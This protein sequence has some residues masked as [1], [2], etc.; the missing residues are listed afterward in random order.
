[1]KNWIL[2]HKK[3]VVTA[4]A[5]VVLIMALGIF[6]QKKNSIEAMR[7]ANTIVSDY[8]NSEME[9]WGEVMYSRVESISIDFPSEVTE[10]Q[11][12]E[13]ERVTLGQTLVTIDLSEYNGNIEKLRQ[14]LNA[15]EAALASA[16]QD[17]SALQTDIANTQKDIARKSEEYNNGTNA[18]IKLLNNSLNLAKKQ[19]EDA[20]NDLQNYQSLYDEGAV[21]KNTLDQYVDIVNQRQKAVD[22]LDTSIQKTKIAL[23]DELSL[24]NVSLKSKQAQLSQ[25]QQGN[26]TNVAVQ[27]SSVSV[28]EVDLNALMNKSL[29]DYIKDNQIVSNLNNGIVKNISIV[30]GSRLGTQG[31]PTQ[32]LQ[33]ID[34]DS[35]TVSAEVY[36]EF[37]GSVQVGDTVRIVP[38]SSPDLS[39]DGTVTHIPELAVEK[40]GRRVVRVIVKPDD[41]NNILKPGF[42][43]EVY[44]TK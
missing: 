16:T 1:M 30:N 41:P 25:L 8:Q 18:D 27:Q 5:F 13:G 22:D 29:R 36:E 20:K 28:T 3:V 35:I 24:L 39:L 14:Q 9:A 21:S 15:N 19:L 38:S 17:I 6:I 34:A 42:T 37:I 12:K 40:D 32:V 2:S 26:T 7:E 43:A 23:K 10:V 33:I 44:F 4:G 31:V 11:V